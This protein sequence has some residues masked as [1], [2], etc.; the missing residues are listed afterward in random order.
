MGSGRLSLTGR[1]PNGQW[2]ISHPRYMWEISASRATVRGQDLGE[3]G[4]L[5]EQ[6]HLGDFWVPQQGRF[7]IG[8]AFLE[9]YDPARHLA[10]FS[11]RPSLDCPR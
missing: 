5:P 1:L 8:Q 10:V 3:M 2:F 6:A 4:P 11:R 7:F 9:P